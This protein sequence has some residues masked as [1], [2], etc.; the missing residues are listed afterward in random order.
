MG[1]PAISPDC[2]MV[3]WTDSFYNYVKNRILAKNPD[4]V[5]GGIAQASDWPSAEITFDALYLVI[6]LGDPIRP[7]APGSN[8]WSDPLYGHVVQWSWPILGDDIKSDNISASRSSRYRKNFQIMQE[9]LHGMFPGF[10]EK[11]QYGIDDDG[12]LIS[13]S[14]E[15]KEFIWFNKPR[16]STKI[17]RSTGTLFGSASATISGFAPTINS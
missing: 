1:S 16:L 7:E 3:D 12:Q 11:L 9:V 6:G 14:Y 2:T 17:D 10:C 8:S 5:F 4:R 15:P 13:V